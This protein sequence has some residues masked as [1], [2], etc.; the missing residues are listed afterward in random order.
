[1]TQARHK[2]IVVKADP[3]EMEKKFDSMAA[4]GWELV[5]LS[6]APVLSMLA[7]FRRTGD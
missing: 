1:M 3:A 2:V 4:Q 7:V 5:S 6:Q